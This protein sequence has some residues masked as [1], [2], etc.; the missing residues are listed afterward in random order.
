MTAKQSFNSKKSVMAFIV[1]SVTPSLKPV[2]NHVAQA[3]F[4]IENRLKIDP[5]L[6]RARQLMFQGDYEQALAALPEVHRDLEIR[7]VAAVCM[8]RLGRFKDAID[9]LRTVTV[10]SNINRMRDD[11]PAHI[12][13]NFAI[14]LFYGGQ[15]AGGLEALYEVAQDDEPSVIRLREHARR[16]V[17]EMSFLR[18]LDWRM[19]GIAPKRLPEP[20]AEPLGRCFWDLEPIRKPGETAA[21]AK[22]AN[23]FRIGS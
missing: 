18:R 19:N 1:K 13:I 23:G 21:N 17:S 5:R 2:H 8:I 3:T 14:A 6:R 9:L 22:A 12:R 10:N 20:P 15:P 4:E 16:W 7:N 11:V